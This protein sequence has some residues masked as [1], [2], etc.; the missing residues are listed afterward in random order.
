MN[1]AT[2]VT[3]TRRS[4]A[5]RKFPAD[6][7][8][9][10]E[11]IAVMRA[12]GDGPYALRLRALIVILWRS[13]LRISEALALAE[14]DLERVRGSLLVRRGKGGKRREVG[15]DDWAWAQLGAWIDLRRELP[16]GPLLCLISQPGCGR[17][18]NGA[19]VRQ[20]LRLVAARAGVTAS[21][22]GAPASPR[23]C[24]RDGAGRR[25]AKRDSTATRSREPRDHEH[26]PPGHRHGGD[27]E[28][29]LSPT[30]ADGLGYC[31]PGAVTKHILRM[32]SGTPW[33]DTA[34]AMSGGG[35]E[36][37]LLG[38]DAWGRRDVEAVMA[39]MDQGQGRSDWR[40]HTGPMS[41]DPETALN[42]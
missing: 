40:L 12:A 19:S 11:I 4:T 22:C 10:E 8:R 36:L 28:Y 26:L 17:P 27:R 2:P 23:S 32:E 21:V 39:L 16:V 6:P 41:S 7:P 1:E 37:I 25:P 14:T 18:W 15:M 30:A 13:G 34:W 42:R 31:R 3:R 33:R 38:T 29:R 35:V 24:G 20:S 5:G 9:V